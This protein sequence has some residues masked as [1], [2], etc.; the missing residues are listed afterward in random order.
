MDIQRQTTSDPAFKKAF[1]E[2]RLPERTRS[3]VA[4]TYW[5]SRQGAGSPKTMEE[6]GFLARQWAA[7]LERLQALGCL[8]AGVPGA[9]SLPWLPTL[10]RCPWHDEHG[11]THPDRP[12]AYAPVLGNKFK[13]EYFCPVCNGRRKYID[14]V[15]LLD[16]DWDAAYQDGAANCSLLALPPAT[17][18]RAKA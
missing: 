18:R 11:W 8:R 3:M 13:G 4:H 9:R 5:M 7:I 17:S 1:D 16:E 14:L 6:A 12:E 2:L 10:R 15:G